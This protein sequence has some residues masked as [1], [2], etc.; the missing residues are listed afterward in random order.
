V[1]FCVGLGATMAKPVDDVLTLQVQR[2]E[3]AGGDGP[4][5][6]DSI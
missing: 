5:V 2:F 4:A 1:D 3:E 6:T